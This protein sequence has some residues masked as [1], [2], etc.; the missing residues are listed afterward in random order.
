M[1][2]RSK[3][4]IIFTYSIII[5]AILR[6]LFIKSIPAGFRSISPNALLLLMAFA[7]FNN[8]ASVVV[9]INILRA[10]E[11]ARKFM[12][13]LTIIGLFYMLFVAAPLSHSSIEKMRIIPKYADK[14]DSSYEV[15]SKELTE[16]KSLTKEKYISNILT[17]IH[18]LA[19][20]FHLISA[21]YLSFIIYCFTRPKVKE[22]FLT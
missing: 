17:F 8:I 5:F 9:G 1:K 16:E 20:V 22:Q 2:L 14:F 19:I 7:G 10:R 21:I 11:W 18:L 12:V 15:I 13:V 6:M 3:G 4:V